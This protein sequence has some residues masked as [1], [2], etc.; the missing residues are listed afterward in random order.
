M[1][2]GAVLVGA[3]TLEEEQR[4]VDDERHDVE[5]DWNRGGQP[6]VLLCRAHRNAG[7]KNQ[8][9][10]SCVVLT[11]ERRRRAKATPSVSQDKASAASV[12]SARA[13]SAVIGEKG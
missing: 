9:T 11:C 10:R 3:Q 4:D 5:G 7:K 1:P 12:P 6:H 13:P 8:D 2:S